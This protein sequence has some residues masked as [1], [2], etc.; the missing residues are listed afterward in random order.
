MK[1]DAQDVLEDPN[2]VWVGQENLQGP[3]LIEGEGFARW[4]KKEDIWGSYASV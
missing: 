2:H 1:R 3:F 4:T